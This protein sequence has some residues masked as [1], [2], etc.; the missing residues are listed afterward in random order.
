[1]IKVTPIVYFKSLFSIFLLTIF[2]LISVNAQ[3]LPQQ[4]ATDWSIVGAECTS[5]TDTILLSTLGI[6][7]TGGT[8]CSA[9]IVSSFA[10]LPTSGGVVVFPNGTFRI[11]SS[12][13]IPDNIQLLGQGAANTILKFDL[14][15]SGHL[16]T[17]TGAIATQNDTLLSSALKDSHMLSITDASIYNSGDIIRIRENDAGRITSSW[18]SNTIGQIVRI[19]SINTITN[20]L[21]IKQ[22]IHI[23]FNSAN[24]TRIQKITPAE[25]IKISCLSLIRDDATSGQ[26]SN[27][28][29]S[30]AYNCKL[31]GIA[32]YNCNN[33][34]VAMNNSFNNA[35]ENSYFED[36]HSYGAGGQG[37]G[38]TV[39]ITSCDNLIQ[40]NI[41]NHLRHSMLLQAGANGNVFGY[42]YSLNPYWTGVSLPAASAGDMVLH[43]N[44]VFLNLFEGN[45]CQNIVI[46]DSHGS[47]GPYNTFFRNRAELYGIFMNNS[48]ASDAQNFIGNEI[49]NSGFLLG[50]YNLSGTNHFEFA[51][52]HNGTIKPSGTSALLDTSYYLQTQPYFWDYNTSSNPTTSTTSTTPTTPFPN[53]GYPVPFDSFKNIANQNYSAG[54][55]TSCHIDTLDIY[56]KI[57]P[58]ASTQFLGNNYDTSGIFTSYFENGNCD[59]FYKLHLSEHQISAITWVNDTL[60]IA[61]SGQSYEWFLDGNSI[62]NTTNAVQPLS[63]GNYEVAVTFSDNTTCYSDVYALTNLGLTRL[64]TPQINISPNPFDSNINILSTKP[65]SVSIYTLNGQ[66]V[67]TSEQE[68]RH[69]NL[70]L[71]LLTAGIYIL[72]SKDENGTV[73]YS[74]IVKTNN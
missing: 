7:A 68:K 26:T 9:I 55:I 62:G 29:M 46:D 66:L 12:I 71:K 27:I 53:I 47:N 39:Q 31:E 70:A 57:C 10:N 67:Y 43:G 61:N 45:I 41:F 34:H 69:H 16:L 8:D 19:D 22:P 54:A 30:Y 37:Y 24:Y 11:N 18:A 60:V 74:K 73:V 48:P 23:D 59:I 2:G 3:N 4:R 17:L 20:T 13:N 50:M 44:F 38:V 58:N 42:N 63:N 36:A 40:N 33:A 64:N 14:G 21:F 25:N 51:N 56:K 35:V 28:Y 1:M 6:D 5:Y 32:S 72:K 15:G 52:N 65:I 49:T